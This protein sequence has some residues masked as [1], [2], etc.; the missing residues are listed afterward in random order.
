MGKLLLF[1]GQF[2]DL[3]KQGVPKFRPEALPPG[4][5]DVKGNVIILL[6]SLERNVMEGIRRLHEIGL[7]TERKGYS[8]IASKNRQPVM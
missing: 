7:L 8:G 5:L 4:D 6:E 2:P 1:L 3:A